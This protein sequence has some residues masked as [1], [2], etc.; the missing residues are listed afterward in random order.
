MPGISLYGTMSV[1]LRRRLVM[2]MKERG[3]DR[4]GGAYSFHWSPYLALHLESRV[5]WKT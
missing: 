3:C 5:Q 2:Q 4:G 1:Y